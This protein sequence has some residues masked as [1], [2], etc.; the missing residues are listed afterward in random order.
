MSKD[1]QLP[2]PKSITHQSFEI[3]YKKFALP[4]MKFLVKRMGGNMDAAEEVFSHTVMAAW[5]GY[6]T[7]EHKSKFFTW[8]CRIGLNKMADYYRAEINRRSGWIAPGLEE[9]ANIG[10]KEISHEERLILNELRQSVKDCIALLPPEKQ[11]LLHLRYYKEMT[12]K[13]IAEALG[14]SERAAEGKLYRAR[15]ELR[16]IIINKYPEYSPFSKK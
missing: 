7:F 5:R 8:L 13:K 14:I 1:P 6:H 12:L 15:I 11:Q 9:L 2:D 16:E 4:L 3:L 10:S